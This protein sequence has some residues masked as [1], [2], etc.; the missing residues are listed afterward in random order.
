MITIR[1]K[2]LCVFTVLLST[3]I[4]VAAQD[5]NIRLSVKFILDEHGCRPGQTWNGTNC[6]GCGKWTIEDSIQVAID[7]TNE[8]LRRW[9]RGYQ[10]VIKE[11]QYVSGAEQFYDLNDPKGDP[12]AGDFDRDGSMDDVAI[13]RLSFGQWVYDFNHNA[14]TDLR[15]EGWGGEEDSSIA[16]DFDRDG[17]IDDVAV[18]RPSDEKWYYDFDHDGDT[19]V[20]TS[21]WGHEGDLPIAGDFDRDGFIDDVAVFRPS[22]YQWFYDFDYDGDTDVSTS[23]WGREGDQPVAGDFDRDGFMDDVAVFRDFTYE[24]FYDFD[25][26]GDT[27]LWIGGWGLKDDRPI[28]GDFD[29]DGWIDDVA[30]FRPRGKWFYDFDHDGNTDT[31]TVGW[32]NDEKPET[33]AED[34]QGNPIRSEYYGLEDVARS[35]STQFL[36]RDDATN[37]FIVNSAPWGGAAA[38]P[39]SDYDKRDCEGEG[40]FYE[41]VVITANMASTLWP[42]ELGHHNNLL[43]PFDTNDGVDD[44]RRD[45]YKSS[46]TCAENVGVLQQT[47]REDNW[48]KHEYWDIIYNNMGYWC[49]RPDGGYKEVDAN[50]Y[51]TD[52]EAPDKSLATLRM[53]EGQLDRWTDAT[54]RYHPGEVSGFT[55]FVNRSN[56]SPPFN[57][58]SADPFPTV[59]DGVAAANPAGGDIVLIRA[60]TYEERMT[61]S[62]PVTLRASCGIVTIGQ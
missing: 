30:V 7:K 3:P 43:H 25:H 50:F 29:R 1:F 60:G 9:G 5:I 16:G 8:V 53:T 51:D 26:D 22:T 11:F 39:S 38:I 52:V 44:L 49:A 17:F 47:A 20:S 32:G 37:V 40:H 58:Y 23:G 55:Y 42:H 14:D 2:L 31:S 45:P 35:N 59:V 18:F 12:V 24:W 54:R 28:A 15:I 57:G 33:C 13:F 10:Y 19:D 36:W 6:I 62:K 61:I 41:L 34:E 46:R 56:T 4:S 21:G 27:D 48:K